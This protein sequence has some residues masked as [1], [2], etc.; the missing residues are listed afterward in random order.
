[1]LSGEHWSQAAKLR[2][3]QGFVSSNSLFDDAAPH[4]DKATPK[5]TVETFPARCRTTR[6]GEESILKPSH[7]GVQELVDLGNPGTRREFVAGTLSLQ[8]GTHHPLE[9]RWQLIIDQRGELH[10]WHRAVGSD[11]AAGKDRPQHVEVLLNANRI[12]LEVFAVVALCHV[13]VVVHA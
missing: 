2:S 9:A 4:L 13:E 6:G 10:R 7:L 5:D 3:L 11:P 8:Q 12:P 1:M